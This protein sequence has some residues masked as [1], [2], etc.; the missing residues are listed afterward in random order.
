MVSNIPLVNNKN[1]KVIINNHEAIFKVIDY[2][3]KFLGS[4]IYKIDVIN[5][6]GITDNGLFYNH[7]VVTDMNTNNK[8]NYDDTSF[9]LS[10]QE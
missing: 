9:Q 1:Y 10:V 8:I 5:S 4:N 7:G 3:S 6:G 2:L